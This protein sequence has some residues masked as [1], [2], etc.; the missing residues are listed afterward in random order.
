MARLHSAEPRKIFPGTIEQLREIV[1]LTGVPGE[2]EWMRASYWRYRCDDGAILNWW[3]STGTFNFQGPAA[4]ANAFKWALI[5][6]VALT[7]Y[8][9]RALPDMRRQD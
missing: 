3:P 4:A 5:E 1:A 2:W 9:V 8:P 6:V 7:Q